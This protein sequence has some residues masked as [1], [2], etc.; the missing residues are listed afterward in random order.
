MTPNWTWTLN[1]QKYPVYTKDLPQRPQFVQFRS[2]TTVSEIQ[3]RQKS[4]C[5]EWSQTELEHLAVKSILYTL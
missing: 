4:E 2:T 5:T 3:G 1:S